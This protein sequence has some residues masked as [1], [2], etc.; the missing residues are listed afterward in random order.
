MA[1]IAYLAQVSLPLGGFLVE[2]MASI[3]LAPFDSARLGNVEAFGRGSVGFF[4][5]A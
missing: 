5:L 2:D 4:A 1:N 3:S